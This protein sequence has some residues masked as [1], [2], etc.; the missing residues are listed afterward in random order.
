MKT[1]RVPTHS[2]QFVLLTG[3]VLIGLGVPDVRAEAN[4]KNQ[5]P[6]ADYVRPFVGAQGEGNTYPGPSAPFGMVQLSPDTDKTN[7]DTASGYEYTDPTILGFSLTHLSGTGCPDL[8]DFLFMPQV[9]KPAFISG[10]KD[11]PAEGYQSTFSHADESASAGY[12]KVKLQKSGV[13]V[14]LTA[15]ERAGILRFTFPASDE[16]SIMT[17]LSHV[18]N[19]G[20]WRV[21]QSHVRIED[22]STV[23]GFHLINGWAKERYL[24][25]AARYSRPFD[26]AEI[27]SA[28]KPV[29]YNTYRFRS[30]KEAAGT[31][32]QFIARYKTHPN[33]VVKVK[34][35]VSAVSAANALENLDA[36]IP[37]W[38][39]AKL[40][41]ATRAKWNRELSKIEI[42]GSPEQ[43][44]TF[45]TSLYHAFLA[46]NLYQDVN[47]EYRGFDQNIHKAKGFTEYSV[48]S[49]WD[50][51]RATHPLFAL[52]QSRRDADMINSLLVHYDQSVDHL[53]PMWELQ[54]NETWC[55]IGYHAVPVI[56]DGYLKGVKGFDVKHAYEAIKTTAMNP[57]Y[58]G[59]A[60]Y[61]KLG[62]VPCDKEDENV[63]KT[64][65]YAFDDYCIA[66][67]ARALGKKNDYDNFMKRAA[68]YKNLYDPTTG[69][70]RPKDS[71]GNWRT[72]FNPHA[73]GGDT[74]SDFTEGT[75]SQYSW[76]VPQDVP[77]LI[78]L[79]GGKEKF[80][81]KL[82][83]LFT[84]GEATKELSPNDQRGC[85][86]EYWHGN[87]PSH[88]VIYLYCYAGQPWKAAQRLHQIVATQYGSQPG[89]LCGNDDCGQ[90]SAWY[91]FTC[92]GFY[93][94]CP[95]GDYYVIGA[96]Q[97][98]KA[99]MHLSNGKNFTMTAENISDKNIYVQSVKLNGRNWDSPFLPY[100]ELKN[101]GTIAFTMGTQPSRWG[102]NPVAPE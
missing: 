62:W 71:Q 2:F 94:V 16:A 6:L 51:Y 37:D 27:I 100:E 45:Y 11:Q 101:G 72:P 79:M 53:L 14:E 74:N 52:I 49:L 73:F 68:S 78:A 3:A 65:E 19:G 61:R 48:F 69:W 25:F 50:T 34:V 46:P 32:L 21:A 42:E 99:V 13:M 43:K 24:Y 60:A 82:D 98:K 12:Y 93:P 23:T 80:I 56:V 41:A 97:I 35:A 85:I 44:E 17:D 63:S 66:Q 58:D 76:Y 22:N 90:M 102:T 31:N 30:S 81:E 67:M 75:S 15:A 95:A 96:P 89:S 26:S 88:H 91:M 33:E 70:M 20:R 64:L 1:H 9:G 18:I 55:M 47:G 87:E 36:E 28:G 7:W 83:S 29:V 10:M 4:G 39:F 54:G 8:G 57:D 84:S 59:L 38:D 77:G 40:L 86:G 5:T 92:M